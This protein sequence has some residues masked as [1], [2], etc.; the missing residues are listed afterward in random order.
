MC[1]GL[2]YELLEQYYA[3]Q[4]SWEDYFYGYCPLGISKNETINKFQDFDDLL[5]TALRNP[6]HNLMAQIDHSLVN[7]L[8]GK[9]KQGMLGGETIKKSKKIEII[10]CLSKVLQKDQKCLKIQDSLTRGVQLNHI[11]WII[12]DK[13]TKNK[14]TGILGRL[15]LA[16]P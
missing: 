7:Q 11:L 5:S 12:F 2:V 15:I 10:K 13:T 6:D 1:R 8:K 16:Y 14:E 3:K 4:K 9:I